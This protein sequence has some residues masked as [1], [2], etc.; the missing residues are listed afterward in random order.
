MAAIGGS[1]EE[2]SI[3]GRI[4]AVASDADAT[5]KLG[6][7]ENEVQANGNGTGRKIMTR[8][9][10][11]IEGLTVEIDDQAGDHEFLQAVANEKGYVPISMTLASGVTYSADGTLT[12]D[13]G[14]SS[15]NATCGINL[16]GPGS[17]GAQSS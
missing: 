12:G 13:L 16:S 7:F 9:P 11:S 6:G 2:V 14:A 3:K 10:W 17:L 8:V 1:V 4:F 5:K 15:Q